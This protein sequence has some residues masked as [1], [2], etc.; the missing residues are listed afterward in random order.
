VRRKRKIGYASEM[1][2]IGDVMNFV[3]RDEST[4]WKKRR[5]N[6]FWYVQVMEFFLILSLQKV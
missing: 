4:F 1:I 6:I 3:F 5:K 2:I